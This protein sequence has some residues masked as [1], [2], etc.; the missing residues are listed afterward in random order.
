MPG[1]SRE[2]PQE[3]PG[4][5]VD[6]RLGGGVE[7]DLAAR[8]G[9]LDDGPDRGALLDRALGTGRSPGHGRVDHRR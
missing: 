5:A 6:P 4:A 2:R 1:G 7:L 9:L 3:L 8:V